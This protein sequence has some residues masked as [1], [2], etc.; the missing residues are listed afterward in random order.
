VTGDL[1][2]ATHLRKIFRSTRWFSGLKFSVVALDN[3]SVKIASGKTLA[4]VGPSGSGKTTLARCIARL[5][6]ATSGTVV[7]DG[8]DISTLRGRELLGIRKQIQF[9]FQDATTALNPRFTAAEIIEEPLAISDWTVDDRRRRSLELMDRVQLSASLANRLPGQLSGGQR[10]RLGIARALTL[11]PKLLILDEALSGIDLS[12]QAQLINLLLDLQTL[13]GLTYLF[14][15][16]DPGLVRSIAHEVVFMEHGRTVE[17][18]SA[19]N[20]GRATVQ[21]PIATKNHFAGQAART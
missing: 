9:V 11:N 1:L 19:E 6:E 8:Q 16:H 14:I 12:I 10:Q 21:N 3:A 7:F 20:V 4:L 18:T 5:E 17:F 15:S 13:F 2:V